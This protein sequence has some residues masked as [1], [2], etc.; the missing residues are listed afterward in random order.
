MAVEVV[1]GGGQDGLLVEHVFASALLEQAG[2]LGGR[3]VAPGGA[4]A[5]VVAPAGRAVHVDAARYL[6]QKHM[7]FVAGGRREEDLAQNRSN[8]RLAVVRGDVGDPALDRVEARRRDA[9]H[10]AGI[11]YAEE[12][13]AAVGVREG[14]QLTREVLGVGGQDAA[15]AEA[16]GLELGQTVLSGAELV[17]NPIS[18]VEHRGHVQMRP[19]PARRTSACG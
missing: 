9:G 13:G 16:E 7:P 18:R 3:E 10:G 11:V 19:H 2:E 6:G 12:D 8:R 4:D 5:Q 15:V 14:N 17:Q 1:D